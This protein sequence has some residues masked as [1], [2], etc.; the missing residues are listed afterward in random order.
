MVVLYLGQGQVV[1]LRLLAG[2]FACKVLGM[3]IAGETARGFLEQLAIAL[4]G[5]QPGIIGFRILDVADML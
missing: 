5:F 2:P 3:R 1:T 4:L